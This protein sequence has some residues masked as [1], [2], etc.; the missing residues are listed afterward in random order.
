M[1]TRA[2]T[3]FFF[4]IVMLASLFLGAYVFSGFFLLLSLVCLLEFY[5]IIKVGG[6]SP[7]RFWGLLLA[8][9]LF[10]FAIGVNFE[11]WEF[12]DLL[13]CSPLF[14]IPF[15]SALYV[16]QEQPFTG[17]AYTYLG[18]IFTTI[19]FIFFYQLGFL[20]QSSYDFTLVLGFLLLL[21]AND[22][23]AYL[24][25]MRFGKRKLFERHSPKKS[26]EGF[27]GG[28]FIALVVSFGL[29]FWMPTGNHPA[30]WMGMALIISIIGTMGD[31]VES[32]LKRS[33]NVKDSGNILPGHGGFL[34][35]FD[36]LFISAPMVYAYWYAISLL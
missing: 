23:G 24:F 14:F 17:I 22:T 6:I 13:L 35:R 29:G 28:I 5:G 11:L 26:W 9:C 36:G 34:D 32:M 21:W 30:F 25:G 31:L 19:P 7:H 4:T 16:K 33:L 2:I 27:L 18:I 3:A 15:L 10:V 12:K 20:L 8:A 1:K